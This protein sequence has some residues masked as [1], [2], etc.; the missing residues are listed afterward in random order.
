MVDLL[1]IVAIKS[2]VPIRGKDLDITGIS[3]DDFVA[4]L[5]RFPEL[6]KAFGE[7]MTA[8]RIAD[9]APAALGAVIAAGTGHG[10]SSAHEQ[11]ARKLVIGDQLTIIKAILDVSLPQGLRPFLDSL[12]EFGLDVLPPASPAASDGWDS[13]TTLPKP[14]SSSSKP[15]TDGK[16]SAA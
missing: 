12:R 11:A 16:M 14:P 2:T 7:G 5:M 15:A 13:V 6:Q 8:E 10:G 1:D 4:L 3:F 9:A